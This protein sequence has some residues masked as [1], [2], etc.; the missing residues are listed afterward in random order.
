MMADF[1]DGIL[2]KEEFLYAHKKEFAQIV[3]RN[4]RAKVIIHS[5]KDGVAT[6]S[7]DD[8]RLLKVPS[9]CIHH[10]QPIIQFKKG[11]PTPIP[12]SVQDRDED[13]VKVINEKIGIGMGNK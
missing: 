13:W 2:Y 5:E 9:N 11:K 3:W 10:A 7:G 12:K 6:I 1:M 4:G 8:F